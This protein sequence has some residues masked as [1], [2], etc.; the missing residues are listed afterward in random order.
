MTI[1]DQEP[2]PATARNIEDLPCADDLGLKL[3]HDTLVPFAR[4]VFAADGPQFMRTAD[5]DLI[6]YRNNDLQSFGTA[7]EVG[8]VPP[9][10][11]FGP[12]YDALEAGEPI[13]GSAMADV[14]ANQVFAMN[15]PVHKPMRR[16]ITNR[17]GPRQVREMEELA[18]SVT[19][20]IVDTIDT[21]VPVDGLDM[22][23]ER[24]TCGFF[25][26]LLGM[27][28][29]EI[30]E[31][32]R[33]INDF[34][35]LFLV[36]P[37]P[38]HIARY[39]A[40]A[41]G[42]RALLDN[43]AQRG[44]ASDHPFITALTSDLDAVRALNLP[45][46]ASTIGIVPPHAGALLAGNLVD[47]Y[48]TAAVGVA[49][50]LY[51]LSQQPEALE[52]IRADRSLLLPAIFESL[53]LAPPVIALKRWALEDFEVASLQIPAGTSIVMM[54]GLGGF[55]PERFP[56]PETFDL[57]RPRQGSTTFGGGHHLCPG[58]HLAP[59]LIQAVIGQI[60][61]RQLAFDPEGTHASWIEGSALGQM[62]HLEIRFR[63][64]ES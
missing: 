61:D 15:P 1:Q 62:S 31:M 22:F 38:E 19:G 17:F 12:A 36:P 59:M 43:A 63:N 41:K 35:A 54:W 7:P 6:V 56:D 32:E 24:V 29:G 40:A 49:N 9:Q 42:Y 64:H 37:T 14:I 16:T 25:G 18:W 26:R 11:I 47:G 52:Y 34:T 3:G 33:Y 2:L 39:D 45:Q 21:S 13:P 55:D 27:D 48:H 4:H 60:L 57:K 23:S 50:T 20:G 58:R 46:D 30:A 8:T 44:V 10:V 28:S 51:I 53:R 5:G